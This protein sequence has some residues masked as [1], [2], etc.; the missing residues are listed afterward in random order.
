MVV[1][2]FEVDTTQNREPLSSRGVFL[3][4]DWPSTGQVCVSD[5]ISRTNGHQPAQKQLCA[6]PPLTACREVWLLSLV[7]LVLR[8]FFV[9]HQDAKVPPTS[10][11]A[12]QATKCLGCS[13]V[14]RHWLPKPPWMVL[15]KPSQQ[16]NNCLC[17]LWC[18]VT[19]INFNNNS[20]SNLQITKC[21]MKEIRKKLNHKT[22]KFQSHIFGQI[23]ECLASLSGQ[24]VHRYPVQR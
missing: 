23:Y 10:T 7:S 22:T 14:V 3:G 24:V 4:H 13:F 9:G 18:D 12:C 11:P 19:P 6:S 16:L 17:Q 20:N 21:M 8:D 2:K 1:H 5:I 15:R